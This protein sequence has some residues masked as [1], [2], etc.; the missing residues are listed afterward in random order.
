MPAII[1]SI[2][3]SVWL[4]VTEFYAL[5]LGLVPV[6]ISVRTTWPRPVDWLRTDVAFTHFHR[7][8]AARALVIAAESTL[9]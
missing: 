3:W 7:N 5:D 4:A 6:Y 9:W 1:F 8:I 2:N